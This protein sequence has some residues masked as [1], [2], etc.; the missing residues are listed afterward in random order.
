[1]AQQQTLAPEQ[2]A[3]ATP[4]S[5][6]ARRTLRWAAAASLT[7]LALLTL[8]ALHFVRGVERDLDALEVRLLAQAAAL[9][10]E[11]AA[12][13]APLLGPAQEGNAALHYRSLTYAWGAEGTP[14]SALPLARRQRRE[15]GA[16]TISPDLL[17]DLRAHLE[18]GEELYPE[19]LRV[20][21]ERLPLLDHLSAGVRQ[22]RCDWEPDPFELD[23]YRAL[24]M[25]TLQEVA[26]IA[27]CAAF[28]EDD[29]RRAL[30]RGLELVLFAQDLARFPDMLYAGEALEI[31]QVGLR[32]LERTLGQRQHARA[33]LEWTRS[34]LTQLPAWDLSW[35]RRGDRL[36]ERASLLWATGRLSGT[37]LGPS[38]HLRDL[39]RQPHRILLWRELEG[40]ERFAP[41][42]DRLFGL[43]PWERDAASAALGVEIAD[44]GYSLAQLESA[45]GWALTH[46]DRSRTLRAGISGLIQAHLV[47]L[48]QGE[49]PYDLDLPPDPFDPQGAPLGY[50]RDHEHVWIRTC[51]A[52][53]PLE[54][55]SSAR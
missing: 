20:F 7:L 28:R 44:S 30:E 11:A 26:L 22:T 21:R 38:K 13:R 46:V 32:S 29:P 6:S 48:E 53:G 25:D 47:R 51:K 1:L 18:G 8:A 41:Q 43:P 3:P 42:G 17:A 16:R 35:H 14:E 45:P 36:A 50:A 39:G 2:E 5:R 15:L 24:P 4:A 12:E 54:L 52:G 31:E 34:V 37:S 23:D 49:F 40:V 9:R 10:D 27:S 33:D 19:A 55:R